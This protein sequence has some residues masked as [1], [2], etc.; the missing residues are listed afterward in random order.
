[1]HDTDILDDEKYIKAVCDSF[2]ESVINR[3][4]VESSLREQPVKCPQLL[5]AV[6]W[7]LKFK[8][9]VLIPN[10]QLKRAG[11]LELLHFD[12]F[13]RLTVKRAL[14]ISQGHSRMKQALIDSLLYIKFVNNLPLINRDTT[15]YQHN[16]SDPDDTTQYVS[17]VALI[18]AKDEAMSFYVLEQQNHLV[19][20]LNKMK[21]N[22]WPTQKVNRQNALLFR[23]LMRMC[24]NHGL[25]E[26]DKKLMR[27]GLKNQHVTDYLDKFVVSHLTQPAVTVPDSLKLL[28]FVYGQR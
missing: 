11:H 12:E 20:L 21:P 26:R 27:I 4:T 10:S 14:A 22:Q 2:F 1:M 15:S 23:L 6:K 8:L 18:D 7:L 17:L 9:G 28:L 24:T 19:E 3:G 16:F 5:P 13:D 25:S